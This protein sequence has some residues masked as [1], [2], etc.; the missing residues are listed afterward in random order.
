MRNKLVSEDWTYIGEGEWI[1]MERTEDLKAQDIPRE[2][3]QATK[4]L[5]QLDEDIKNH[6][7]VWE[8][9]YPNRFGAKIQVKSKWNLELLESLLTDY[10]D[11]EIVEWLRYGWPTGRL[12]GLAEPKIW[13]KNH[14]GAEEF[15]QALQA[16]I[17]KES[18]HGAIMGPYDK[19]PFQGKV[20]ISPLSTRAKKNSQERRVILDLSFP[21]GEGINDGIPKE[22]YLGL[23]AK[24]T[25]PKTDDFACRIF[26]L[27]RSCA[28]FKIDLS[29]YFRQLPLDPGDYSLIGYIVDGKIYFDKVLP[30]GMRSAPYIAQRITN[31]IAHIHRQ[32]GLFLLNYVDDFVSAELKSKIWEGYRFLTKLLHDLGVDTSKEKL[33]EPCTRM[34]FLGVTFD[35]EKMTMELPEDKVKEINQELDTWLYKTKAR[36]KEVESLIGKLQFAAKCIRIGRVFIARLINW[37]KGLE[38]SKPHSIP[39]EA[40]KDISWWRR[41]LAQYNGVSLL[42]LIKTPGVDTVIATDASQYGYGGIAGKEYFRGKFPQNYS[43]LNIALLELKAVMVALKHWG[44]KL[45]GKYFWIHVDNEAVSII[46]NTGRSR[47]E[48]L[49]DTLREIALIAA[50]H[51]F[52]LKAKHISGVSNR[53]P[54]WLS[55]WN[56]KEARKQFRSHIRDGSFKKLPTPVEM[57]AHTH[58][59]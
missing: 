53:I 4:W 7:E 31:A 30:M 27:G 32:M 3:P 36:R 2:T 14:K 8:K 1:Q 48:L 33:V 29:R 35:T 54:D 47:D 28:M 17:A 58:Q 55:R 40:R 46:L 18:Q 26:Q 34:E 49:Q 37:L 24:L 43:N 19:I 25:F 11:K 57:L 51:Q 56:S 6:L 52:V 22:T 9:G 10:D 12:P 38:R 59:W 44:G 20:G 50:Q 42:W 16:Y 5:K 21:I 39:L 15:P 13:G 23:E 41:Y 45:T